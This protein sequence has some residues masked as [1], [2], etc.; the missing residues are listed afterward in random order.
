LYQGDCAF[1][2]ELFD[3]AVQF[4][5]ATAQ[6]FPEHHASLTA[7]I[8]IVNCYYKLG[9]PN[10]ARV[11]HNRALVRLRQLPESVFEAPDSLLDRDAWARWLQNIPLN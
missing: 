6:R 7:L 11:A 10:R 9:D 4:Y 1:D 2:L 8:Q 3:Q 5:D